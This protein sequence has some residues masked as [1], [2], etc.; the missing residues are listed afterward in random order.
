[1][2]LPKGILDPPIIKAKKCGAQL[3]LSQFYSPDGDKINFTIKC[4]TFEYHFSWYQ[5][6]IYTCKEYWQNTTE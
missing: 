3:L 5:Y 4:H 2:D 6:N 1:M